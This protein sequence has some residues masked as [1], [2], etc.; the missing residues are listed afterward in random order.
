MLPRTTA[1]KDYEYYLWSLLTILLK[2]LLKDNNNKTF[3]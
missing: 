2:I 1:P 3:N